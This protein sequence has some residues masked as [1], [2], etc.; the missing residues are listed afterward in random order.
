[1]LPCYLLGSPPVGPLSLSTYILD[2]FSS[3]AL[4]LICLPQRHEQLLLLSVF[5]F[6][7][8]STCA[9]IGSWLFTKPTGGKDF[10]CLDVQ[11]PNLEG[12]INSKH[13]NQFPTF[14]VHLG[15][16]S[17]SY[18]KSG[19]ATESPTTPTCKLASKDHLFKNCNSEHNFFFTKAFGEGISSLAKQQTNKQ[20]KQR[21][22]DWLP[23]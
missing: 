7:P 8:Q 5:W 9:V 12:W 10:Q 21:S 13:W 11:I 19:V 20:N 15:I 23:L 14:K 6:L 4:N 3:A 2:E 17:L 22:L 1:L 18:W 16:F